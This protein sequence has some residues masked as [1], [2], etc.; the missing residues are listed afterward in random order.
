[1]VELSL[2]ERQR[3]HVVLCRKRGMA[4]VAAVQQRRHRRLL[5]AVLTAWQSRAAERKLLGL[6]QQTAVSNSLA[7]CRRFAMGHA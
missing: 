7:R 5:A 6:Q 2:R 3:K 1:M 4:L